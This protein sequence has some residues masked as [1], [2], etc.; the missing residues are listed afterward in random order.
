MDHIQMVGKYI[1][2]EREQD[3]ALDIQ[4]NRVG[5]NTPKLVKPNFQKPFLHM[6][7]MKTKITSI[8]TLR[9]PSTLF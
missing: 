3:V 6:K 1:F 5:N 2:Q 4:D 8:P 7:M 9:H